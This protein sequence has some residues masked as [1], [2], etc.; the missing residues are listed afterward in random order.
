MLL[1]LLL[2]DLLIKGE[3]F[4]HSLIKFYNLISVLFFFKVRYSFVFKIHSVIKVFPFY[5]LEIRQAEI[6][7][8]EKENTME[9]GKPAIKFIPRTLPHSLSY[10]RSRIKL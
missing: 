9:I 7:C 5:R 3:F 6:N 8:T 1:F 10:S 4:R 2:A